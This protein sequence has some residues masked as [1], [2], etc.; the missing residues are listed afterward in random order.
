MSEDVSRITEQK[1]LKTML[2]EGR[3]IFAK[4]YRQGLAYFVKHGV[5]EDETPEKVAPFLLRMDLNK[6]VVGDMLGGSKDWNKALLSCYVSQLDFGGMEVDEAI[7]KFLS[8]FRLPGEG[9][10]VDR[11]MEAFGAKY[12]GDNPRTHFKDADAV[13][14]LSFAVIMLATDLHSPVV[15]QKLGYPEFVRMVNKDIGLGLSDEYLS[16]VF[17]RIAAKKL[18]LSPSMLEPG[19]ADFTTILDP[20]ERRLVY[21]KE[22]SQWVDV[23]MKLV[24]DNAKRTTNYYHS[25]HIE[26]VRPMFATMWSPTI[27]ALS[28]LLESSTRASVIEL[29]LKGF[30][31]SV[32]I[33][34]I[35]FL[36]TERTA[37]MQALEKFTNL[38][39]RREMELKHVMAIRVVLDVAE[40][41]GDYLQDSWASVL[42][43]VSLLH[44]LQLIGERSYP[45]APDAD[46]RGSFE[47][48]NSRRVTIDEASIDQL[49]AR[50]V[51]LSNKAVVHF[52]RA[53]CGVS[54]DELAASVPR[55][56]SLQ[57]IVEVAAFNMG[58]MRL[59]W[60]EIWQV[61]QRHFARATCHPDEEVAM[62]AIDSLRQLAFKFLEKRELSNYN[63]QKEFMAPFETIVRSHS[64]LK[65]REMTVQCIYRMVLKSSANLHSGWKSV[66]DVLAV[67]ARSEGKLVVL[68]EEVLEEVFRTNLATFV[69]QFFDDGVRCASRYCLATG[70][71]T[72]VNCNSVGLLRLVCER[73]ADGTVAL[74][75]HSTPLGNGY[76]VLRVWLP[77]LAGIAGAT[78]HASGEV[79]H[80]ALAALSFVLNAA[81]EAFS[82]ELW[83]DL[84]DG[85]LLP[86]YAR[87]TPD[88]LHFADSPFVRETY[89]EL[90]QLTEQLVTRFFSRLSD[91][92]PLFVRLLSRFATQSTVHEALPGVSMEFL[93]RFILGNRDNFSESQWAVIAEVVQQICGS[94]GDWLESAFTG[95][96]S[97]PK[98]MGGIKELE[99][100]NMSGG[101]SSVLPEP[102]RA[103]CS[104]AFCKQ[105][106]SQMS[107]TSL[108]CICCGNE[109]YCNEE[110]R[111]SAFEAHHQ[112]CVSWF[113][114]QLAPSFSQRQI[115]I[116]LFFDIETDIFVICLFVIVLL[117]F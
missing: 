86:L 26:C 47:A 12:Y 61:L 76:P 80:S 45:A 83:C 98:E 93:S 84:F 22:T 57:K 90:V 87:V 29:C 18:E 44:K 7:R 91:M 20:Q 27:V 2:E 19:R 13:Y 112:S 100:G 52:V 72:A 73:V 92:A 60:S 49:F 89:R 94:Y 64:S 33:A 10:V 106:L 75:E 5:L 104:C 59:V 107:D 56:F 99:S 54:A 70:V 4:S 97:S 79:R 50:S 23:S 117:L 82:K 46:A 105:P 109:R 85:V 25:S 65:I 39:N 67:A 42:R 81:G 1:K 37:L 78:A 115:G 113:R 116:I 62:F 31:L 51:R 110:C 24:K 68:G 69:Q 58:R 53:L 55:I 63:F 48:E 108:R 111:K 11:F 36:A 3:A 6:T 74:Y 15:K 41:D 17:K 30:S 96:V 35:H 9:P 21:K 114:R 88:G 95:K 14:M 101:S 16:G 102:E 32:H 8:L 40:R 34:A 38:T 77:L 103:E 66:F 71:D 28:L 43:C